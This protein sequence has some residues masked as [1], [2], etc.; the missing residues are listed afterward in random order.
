MDPELPNN[1]VETSAESQEADELNGFRIRQLAA[2]RRA[3]WRSRSY[4]LIA[5]AGALVSAI[6]L[7]V[8]AIYRF[9]GHQPLLR[10]ILY[11]LSA[12]LLVIAAIYFM[13]LAV[14]YHRE[15]QPSSSAQTAARPDFSTLSDG[16]QHARNLERL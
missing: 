15:A 10:P 2:L 11:L 9:A 5:A 3:A 8:N 1:L 6:Q 12:I 7:V 16:S 14:K 4:C 13:R